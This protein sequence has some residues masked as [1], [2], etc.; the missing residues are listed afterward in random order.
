MRGPRVQ[1]PSIL[2]YS[3]QVTS[4]QPPQPRRN[5]MSSPPAFPETLIDAG[6]P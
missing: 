2:P 5:R 1:I 4:G 6:K 3:R